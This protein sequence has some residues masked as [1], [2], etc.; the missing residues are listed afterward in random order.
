MAGHLLIVEDNFLIASDLKDCATKLGMS[1]TITKD[2]QAAIRFATEQQ[3]TAA[4]I[5]VNLNGEFEGLAVARA[6]Y[7]RRDTP[8]V[9]VTGYDGADLAG[10]M[11]GFECVPIVFKPVQKEPLCELLESL[12]R[13]RPPI[14]GRAG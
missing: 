14:T 8:V 12:F 7:D 2:P 9:I 4:I 5:D 1:T 13:S 10:R 11:N 3:F 6:L